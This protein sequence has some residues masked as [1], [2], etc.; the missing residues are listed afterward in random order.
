LEVDQELIDTLIAQLDLQRDEACLFILKNLN[1]PIV[2]LE[3]GNW[4][5]LNSLDSVAG[6]ENIQ[7]FLSLLGGLGFNEPLLVEMLFHNLPDVW[8]GPKLDI[9]KPIRD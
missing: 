3:L 5:F 4:F 8:L 2:I 7:L 1:E 6:V 9:S